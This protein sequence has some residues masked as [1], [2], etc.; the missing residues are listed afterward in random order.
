MNIILDVVMSPRNLAKSKCE[1]SF[2]KEMLLSIPINS[3]SVTVHPK[4]NQIL[5]EIGH[6]VQNEW[7]Q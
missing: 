3:F 5:K 7:E 2:G 1:P 4:S 6:C